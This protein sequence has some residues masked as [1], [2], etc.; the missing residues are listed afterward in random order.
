MSHGRPCSLP[1]NRCHGKLWTGHLQCRV[2]CLFYLLEHNVI[3]L[4]HLNIWVKEKEVL[5][6]RLPAPWSLQIMTNDL[7]MCLLTDWAFSC[8]I[9]P[10][11][12]WDHQVIWKLHCILF[13]REELLGNQ[14]WGINQQGCFR[15]LHVNIFLK[16]K[17]I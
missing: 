1:Y 8:P 7:I 3:E 13:T 16:L 11:P 14:S 17:N 9:S 5:S 10:I 4:A 15:Q 12:G 6:L 2:P